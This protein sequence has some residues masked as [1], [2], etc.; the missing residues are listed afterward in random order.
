MKIYPTKTGES[1][2]Y[3]PDLDETYHSRDGAISESLHV[4]IKEG[5]DRIKQKST[6]IRILEIGFGTGLNTL[7]AAIE[8]NKQNLKIEFTSLE[9]YPIPPEIIKAL[10]YGEVLNNENLFNKIHKVEWQTLS[11]INTNFSIKKIKNKLENTELV[12]QYYDV[13]FFDAFAPKKQ[14]E[15]WELAIFKK[16][17]KSLKNGGILTTYSA[18]G[19]LK[20]NLKQVGFSLHNPPGANGKREMSVAIKP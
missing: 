4:F 18:A 15:L 2:I 11:E 12:T 9:P 8:A 5:L 19:Q 17:Y 20:R 10:N 1:T 7:I 16:L 3:L 14:P 6:P 13:I